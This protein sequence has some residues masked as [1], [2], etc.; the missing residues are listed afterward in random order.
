MVLYNLS[1]TSDKDEHLKSSLNMFGIKNDISH[2]IVK[3]NSL[4][5]YDENSMR[6]S[7]ESKLDKI[8]FP[9]KKPEYVFQFIKSWLTVVKY[10]TEPDHDGSNGKGFQIDID[11]DS[12]QIIIKVTPHWIEYHK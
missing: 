4:F 12:W 6:F 2:F 8:N 10:P 5:L 11:S 7:H 1:I 3:D 9:S